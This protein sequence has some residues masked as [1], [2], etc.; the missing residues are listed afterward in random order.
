MNYLFLIL[1]CFTFSHANKFYYEFDKKVEI[2]S[3]IEIKSLNKTYSDTQEYTT[4]DGKKVKFKNEILVECTLNSYC[5]DDFE[6]LNLINYKEIGTN[7]YLIKLDST[8]DIFLNC[9]KLYEKNDIKSAHPNYV[10]KLI[11]R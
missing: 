5:L 3:T 10:R 4:I 6:D 2:Q 8:Q 7:I 1:F 11:K 9:Q